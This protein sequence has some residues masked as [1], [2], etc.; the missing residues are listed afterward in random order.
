MVALRASDHNPEPP[1]EHVE[2]VD[3]LQDTAGC[4]ADYKQDWSSPFGLQTAK[5]AATGR[6]E[7]MWRVQRE[8]FAG[9][10]VERTVGPMTGNLAIRRP[11]LPCSMVSLVGSAP[12]HTKP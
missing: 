4:T 2:P 12:T 8:I 5:S 10:V 3:T 9:L 7:R 1:E 11:Y 6:R